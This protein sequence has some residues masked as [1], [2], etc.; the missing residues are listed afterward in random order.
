MRK[1]IQKKVVNKRKETKAKYD[2]QK[3]QMTLKL[4]PNV[5]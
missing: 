1:I 5:L 4:T 3:T 2:K